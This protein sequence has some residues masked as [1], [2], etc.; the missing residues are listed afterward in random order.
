MPKFGSRSRARRDTCHED[1]IIVLDAAIIDFDFTILEG[2]RLTETQQKYYTIGRTT[3]LDRKPITNKDGIINLSRHQSDPSTAADCAPWHSE[4][5]HIRW[6][7]TASFHAMAQVIMKAAERLG[8]S[9]SWGGNW[10]SPVDLPH[11]QLRSKPR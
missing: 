1:L 10:K 3:E 6:D 5:P 7:D 9:L 11:F 4:S 8:I 2:H